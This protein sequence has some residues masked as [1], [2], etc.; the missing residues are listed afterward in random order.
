VTIEMEK[1]LLK[2]FLKQNYCCA[3]RFLLIASCYKFSYLQLKEIRI[4]EERFLL[5]NSTNITSWNKSLKFVSFS[6]MFYVQKIKKLANTKNKYSGSIA[7]CL[8]SLYTTYNSRC[9]ECSSY[10]NVVI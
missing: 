1:F 10:V 8:L 9:F 4:M 6:S 3:P 2:F 7:S 5:C